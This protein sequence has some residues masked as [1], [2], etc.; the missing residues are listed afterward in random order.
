[1]ARIVPVEPPYSPENERLFRLVM[2]AGV[3]PLVLFRTLAQSPRVF[4][5]SSTAS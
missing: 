4:P 3:E 1:M 5:V 2:P